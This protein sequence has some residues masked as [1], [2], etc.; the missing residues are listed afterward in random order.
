M[1]LVLLRLLGGVAALLLW[2]APPAEAQVPAELFVSD[3]RL[4]V[5]TPALSPHRT[6]GVVSHVAADTLFLRDS[7]RIFATVPLEHIRRVEI[8]SEG[9]TGLGALWGAATGALVGALA[10]GVHEA[11]SPSNCDYCPQGRSRIVFDAAG[12]AVVGTFI[13]IPV[14]ALIGKDRWSVVWVAGRSDMQR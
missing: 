12:G 13:G 14:G 1:S 8:A 2:S 9:R 11:V 3:T 6:V 4:R 7:R 10:F 5:T